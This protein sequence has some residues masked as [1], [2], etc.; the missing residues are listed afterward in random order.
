MISAKNRIPK[1]KLCGVTSLPF[2]LSQ[3]GGGTVRLTTTLFV[4]RV[5]VGGGWKKSLVSSIQIQELQ[6]IP[7]WTTLCVVDSRER[8]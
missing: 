8:E 7:V 6:Q 3:G 1:K 2:L 5:V 4:T